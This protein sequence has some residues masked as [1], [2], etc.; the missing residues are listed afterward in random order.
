MAAGTVNWFDDAKRFGFII[1]DEGGAELPVHYSETRVTDGF[2]P[3][4][5]TR[6]SG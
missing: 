5:R 2:E 4:P 6:T 1:P 3:S